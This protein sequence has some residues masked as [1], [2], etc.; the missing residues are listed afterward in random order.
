MRNDHRRRNG[1]GSGQARPR[2][3]N[4]GESKNS[5]ADWQRHYDR[6]C[7]LAQNAFETD[8]VTREQYWQHAEH[9]RRLLNGSA[10]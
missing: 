4:G 3:E 8:A 1:S 10:V 9:Y 5:Q 6:Y 7:Q 2:P